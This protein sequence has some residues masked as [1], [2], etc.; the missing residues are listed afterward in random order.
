MTDQQDGKSDDVMAIR[1]EDGA[2]YALPRD[3]VERSRVSA[4][5]AERLQAELDGAD[6][7]AFSMGRPNTS[8]IPKHGI[9]LTTPTTMVG[10][11]GAPFSQPDPKSFEAKL[12]QP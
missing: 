4:E 3:V 8:G 5:V 10:P 11:Y 12:P 1:M 2:W 7:E 6:V 9:V